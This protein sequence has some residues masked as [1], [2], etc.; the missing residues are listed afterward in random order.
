[1]TPSRCNVEDCEHQAA[2]R[3]AGYCHGHYARKRRG[4]PVDEPLRQWGDPRRTV[5]EAALAL[6]D[7]GD[8]DDEAYRI[9]ARFWRAI[10]RF[11]SQKNKVQRR[12]ESSVHARRSAG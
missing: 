7:V 3:M 2:P 9:L 1:M 4:Q 11:K 10:E 8:D 5:F 12:G 6:R